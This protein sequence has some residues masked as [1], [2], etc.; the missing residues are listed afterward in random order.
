[1]FVDFV[2]RILTNVMVFPGNLFEFPPDIWQIDA[3]LDAGE[4]WSVE[5][6]D[7]VGSG[8]PCVL[9]Q[10]SDLILAELVCLDGQ[11]IFRD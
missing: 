2:K 7:V 10:F 9:A 3:A 1:M 4:P 5:C 11:G 8:C 6:L